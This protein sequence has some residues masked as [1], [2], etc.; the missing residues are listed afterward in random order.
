M[1]VHDRSSP[2]VSISVTP[3]INTTRSQPGHCG[4]I[5]SNSVQQSI[6]TS[7]RVPLL[8]TH[9]VLVVVS[10]EA[11]AVI[12]VTDRL[13]G[14]LLLDLSLLRRRLFSVVARVLDVFLCDNS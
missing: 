8:R 13:L 4:T 7:L 1:R 9:S 3:S 5:H 10:V 2:R 11:K 12:L 6:I 14:R